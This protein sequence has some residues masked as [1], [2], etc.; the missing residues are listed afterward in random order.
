MKYETSTHRY[1][2]KENYFMFYDDEILIFVHK[3]KYCVSHENVYNK[4]KRKLYLNINTVQ[5]HGLCM[6]Q[7]NF[8]YSFL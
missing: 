8:I 7:L 5:R 6:L 3:Q 4:N 2:F 1:L